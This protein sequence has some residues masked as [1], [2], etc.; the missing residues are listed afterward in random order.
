LEIH[1]IIFNLE[2]HGLGERLK[3]KDVNSLPKNVSFDFR[4][5]FYKY[6]HS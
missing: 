4:K 5:I 1:G 3:L 2:R 6:L